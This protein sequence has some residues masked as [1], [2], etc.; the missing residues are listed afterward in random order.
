[1]KATELL[2]R[3]SFGGDDVAKAKQLPKAFNV[4]EKN[5]KPRLNIQALR[6]IDWI[7]HL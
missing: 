3:T 6:D 4:I 1:M 2:N 5:I 7:K